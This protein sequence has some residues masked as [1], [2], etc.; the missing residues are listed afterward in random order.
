MARRIR[1]EHI[2]SSGS[3]WLRVPRWA[4]AS[5]PPRPDRLEALGPGAGYVAVVRGANLYPSISPARITVGG[6]ELGGVG[7]ENIVTQQGG[8]RVAPLSRVPGSSKDSH[9]RRP[10]SSRLRRILPLPPLRT[11]PADLHISDAPPHT[12]LRLPVDTV[13]CMTVAALAGVRSLRG[14]EDLCLW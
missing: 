12:F 5:R 7:F 1:S 2:S 11:M 13:R 3:P 8:M 10:S 4:E 9:W 14:K 6:V